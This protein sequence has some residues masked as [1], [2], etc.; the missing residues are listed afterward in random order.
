MTRPGF[1]NPLALP[2][3]PKFDVDPL[4]TARSPLFWCAMNPVSPSF[5]KEP[6]GYL[7]F[8]T[9]G[10]YGESN[11][12]IGQCTLPSSSDDLIYRLGEVAKMSASLDQADQ[13]LY[14]T[15]AH[16]GRV[17]LDLAPYAG[18]VKDVQVVVAQ[19]S[20][21]LTKLWS[22]L[23]SVEEEQREQAA[24]RNQL[25][26]VLPK[27][28]ALYATGNSYH[29]YTNFYYTNVQR[30]AAGILRSDAAVHSTVDLKWLGHA[31][32]KNY[33]SLRLT[34]KLIPVNGK[35]VLWYPTLV[36]YGT[37][38]VEDG[39]AHMNQPQLLELPDELQT[40]AAATPH[41]PAFDLNLML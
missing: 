7:S 24:E 17:V 9:G 35:Q 22:D 18:N 34:P 32:R 29:L 11:P 28:Y 16:Y 20:N 4:L 39:R 23:I 3:R 15:D 14:S 5:T 27:K 2:Q 25:L 40:K 30:L 37:F 12:D 26:P 33:C 13:L 10:S 8:S 6:G 38:T 41:K 19:V 1:L 31:L 21:T 36:A